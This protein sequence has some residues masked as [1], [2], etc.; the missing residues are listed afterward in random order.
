M[1]IEDRIHEVSPACKPDSEG[2][3]EHAPCCH[4]NSERLFDLSSQL[5]SGSSKSPGPWQTFPRVRREQL[6]ADRIGRIP[7]DVLAVWTALSCL[8][9]GRLS[10]CRL[11]VCG[12]GSDA[13]DTSDAEVGIA[14]RL[15]VDAVSRLKAREIRYGVRG[16][17]GGR[18]SHLDNQTIGGGHSL[19]EDAVGAFRL[20]L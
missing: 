2:T 4:E 5:K 18:C 10:P 7:D 11:S 17:L 15:Y 8:S 12:A 9:Q 14:R 1:Q 6:L 19:V 16:A 13:R 20:W 3:P